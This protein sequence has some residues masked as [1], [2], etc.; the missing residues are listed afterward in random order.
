M[1]EDESMSCCLI[2]RFSAVCYTYIN[3][4]TDQLTRCAV[5]ENNQPSVFE[6]HSNVDRCIPSQFLSPAP[7][8]SQ[9]PCPSVDL[10]HGILSFTNCS[11]VAPPLAAVISGNMHLLFLVVVPGLPGDLCFCTWNT[12]PPPALLFVLTGLILPAFSASIS[13]PPDASPEAPLGIATQYSLV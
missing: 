5:K 3:S 11:Y 13:L 8:S 7:F 10:S 2:N 4:F 6:I 1:I 9:S 12:V